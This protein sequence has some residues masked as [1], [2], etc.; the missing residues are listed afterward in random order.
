MNLSVARY[1]ANRLVE[2]GGER[3]VEPNRSMRISPRPKYPN[4]HQL[5]STIAAIADDE[6]V[7]RDNLAKESADVG[8][9]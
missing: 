3:P 6:P 9:A 4:M 5:I 1:N 2:L 8:D 7:R